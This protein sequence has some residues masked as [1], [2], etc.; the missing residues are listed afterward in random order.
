MD[1]EEDN[2]KKIDC[3]RQRVGLRTCQNRTAQISVDLS[4]LYKGFSIENVNL[5]AQ[6]SLFTG[7]LNLDFN[8]K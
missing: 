2:S 8:R 4:L 5:Q 6:L 7:D 1:S 3:K